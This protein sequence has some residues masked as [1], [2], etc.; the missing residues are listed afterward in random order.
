[1]L[2]QLT[3]TVAVSAARRSGKRASLFVA[4]FFS[5][6]YIFTRAGQRK[7]PARVVFK[8]GKDFLYSLEGGA[9][10]SIEPFKS[11]Y[12]AVYMKK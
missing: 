12:S 3:K 6:L 10:K 5:L 8:R 4:R 1:M 11:F 2:Q 9:G 7:N